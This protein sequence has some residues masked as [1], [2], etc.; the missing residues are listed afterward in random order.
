MII[1]NKTDIEGTPRDASGPGWSSVRLLTRNDALGFSVNDTLITA[2]ATLELEYKHHLEACYC[3]SGRGKIT[4]HN[5][6]QTHEI[7]P[8]VLYALDQNDRH[9]VMAETGEDLRLISVFNPALVGT[10]VHGADG[11]YSA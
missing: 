11:S 2:G 10:E 9:T 4:D 6:G 1:V 8:G 3:I 7:F 5:S